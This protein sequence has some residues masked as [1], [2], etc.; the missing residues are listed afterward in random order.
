MKKKINLLEVIPFR[1]EGV[2]TEEENNLAVIVFPRF[3]Y[4]WMYKLP[5]FKSVSPVIRVRLEEHGT[6][7]WRLIDGKRNVQEITVLLA[8]HFNREKNYEARVSVFI[9]QLRKDGFVRYRIYS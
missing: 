5:I 8:E 9:G 7:V 3:K 1:S 6:A 4:A 2:N